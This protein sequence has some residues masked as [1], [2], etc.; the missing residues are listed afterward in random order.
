[1]KPLLLMLVFLC[2][3]VLTKAQAPALLNYQGIARNPGGNV[4]PNK[5]IKLRLSI[6]DGTPAGAVVYS[7][8]R[9]LTTNAFGLFNVAI[10]SAGAAAITGTISSINWGSG[11]KYLQVE[12]DPEGGSLF[13]NMGTSQLLSV[14]YA[15]FAGHSAPGGPAGGALEGT[16]P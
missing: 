4:L 9:A 16:Y 2:T 11:N 12:I 15:L 13:T 10:G 8:T 1:M 14:P 7:E 3:V 6:H 5:N